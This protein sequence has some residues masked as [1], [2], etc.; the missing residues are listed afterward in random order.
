MAITNPIPA[1]TPVRSNLPR[2]MVLL[3][4]LDISS[5]LGI[6]ILFRDGYPLAY[7]FMI[8]FDAALLG[9]AS[10]LGARLI[11]KERRFGWRLLAALAAL[12]SGLFVL[13]IATSWRFGLG[14]LTF[15]PGHLDW[16]GL[17]QLVTGILTAGMALFA[18]QR[19]LPAPVPALDQQPT[20]PAL[21]RNQNLDASPHPEQVLSTIALPLKSVKKSKPNASSKPTSR[22]NARKPEKSAPGG[23]DATRP[24]R[25]SQKPDVQFS[26]NAEFRCPYCLEPVLPDDPRGIVVCKICHTPHHADCW[27]ITGICQVP[28]LNS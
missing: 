19:P 13:G 28:H 10:G 25:R 17:I 21:N 7:L 4:L 6:A 16:S 14:P 18:W 11:L 22:K 23:T 15:K 3:F 9:L 5:G 27:A 2:K 20:Q 26:D 1:P 12:S 8:F 24:K